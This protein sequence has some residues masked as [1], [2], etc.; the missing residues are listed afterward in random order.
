MT[1]TFPAFAKVKGDP[2]AAAKAA[3]SHLEKGRMDEAMVQAEIARDL[4]PE[5]FEPYL[6][7]SRIYES[8][9]KREKAFG[10]LVE[11]GQKCREFP[12]P[13][14]EALYRAA[15]DPVLIVLSPRGK[16][17]SIGTQAITSG[18]KRQQVLKAFKGKPAA[19]VHFAERFLDAYNVTDAFLLLEGFKCPPHLRWLY[20]SIKA[21]GSYLLGNE[22]DF[23]EAVS[24]LAAR[25]SDDYRRLYELG[26][27]SILAGE[28]EAAEKF[29][30]LAKKSVPPQDSEYRQK[31]ESALRN[32]SKILDD[33]AE[34]SGN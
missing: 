18:N 24:E 3:A 27:V 8:Q 25:P 17:I 33:E 28:D 11:A 26:K 4:K 12:E 10:I 21:R 20:L 7:L 14:M 19:L 16:K 5:W 6:L 15:T 34:N 13:G 29:L 31:I 22:N 1:F 30:T 2:Q 9:G 23:T 32:P